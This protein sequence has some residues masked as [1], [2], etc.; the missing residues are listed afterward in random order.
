METTVLN[1][2]ADTSTL[3][4]TPEHS[5]TLLHTTL[6]SCIFHNAHETAYIYIYRRAFPDDIS[7]MSNVS[8]LNYISRC[9]FDKGPA[10]IIT[11]NVKFH[12]CKIQDINASILM[13]QISYFKSFL[14]HFQCN[15]VPVKM[16][17]HRFSPQSALKS[18]LHYL[19][20]NF[21]QA[22]LY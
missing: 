6:H 16:R 15:L 21:V 7:R 19:R 4:C 18:F 17:Y 11:S 2:P 12:G 9:T 5:H 13:S 14:Q 3:T 8:N 22:K 20:L 10:R 1:T